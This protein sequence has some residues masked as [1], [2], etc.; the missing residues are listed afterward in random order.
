MDLGCFLLNKQ[1]EEFSDNKSWVFSQNSK[2]SLAKWSF[3]AYSLI[4]GELIKDIEMES[5]RIQINKHIEHRLR[6]LWFDI[7]YE[8]AHKYEECEKYS[9]KLFDR[10]IL[11]FL[12]KQK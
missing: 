2:I 11:V 5:Q 3:S 9:R 6:E 4:D 7:V 8:N 1:Q 10:L 12:N